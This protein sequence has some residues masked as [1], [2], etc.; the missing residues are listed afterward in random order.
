MEAGNREGRIHPL[1]ILLSSCIIITCRNPARRESAPRLRFQGL[2]Q[3]AR[4]SHG[5]QL[6]SLD[7]PEKTAARDDK[8]G[9]KIKC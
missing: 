9:N 8:K 4:H 3:N 2:A 5:A 6:R 1:P 7:S